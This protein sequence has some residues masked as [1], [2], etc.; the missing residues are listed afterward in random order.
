MLPL[1]RLYPLIAASGMLAGAAMLAAGQLDA[2][3]DRVDL[4]I[5]RYAALEHGGYTAIALALFGLAVLPLLAG[6]RAVRAPVSGWPERLMLGW[7][8]A[9]AGA[10]VL[11]GTVVADVLVAAALM[12]MAGAS[13]LMV[14]RFGEDARW[15]AAARPLEWLALGAGG[16]LAALIYVSLP[17]H[18]DMVGLVQWALFAVDIAVVQVPLVRLVRMVWLES[19]SGAR[20]GLENT[21]RGTA[22]ATAVLSRH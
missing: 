4:T 7:A 15:T 5:G 20:T 12:C 13:A 17:G 16:G 22:H 1:R 3:Y 11:P 21:A 10:A 6:L 19:V 8:G 2:P 18:Q 9:L 14:R